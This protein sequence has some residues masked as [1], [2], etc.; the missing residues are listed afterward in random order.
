MNWLVMLLV[1]LVM[2]V[3]QPVVQNNVQKIVARVQT[4]PQPPYVVYHEGLWW[5]YE[6]G[7]WYVWR[8]AQ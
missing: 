8:P 1:S 3:V 6:K 2:P 5:K 4:Q 7:Q